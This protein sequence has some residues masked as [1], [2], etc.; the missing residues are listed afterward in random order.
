M[1]NLL[2]SIVLGLLFSLLFRK[3][4]KENCLV[5]ET[6]DP[7]EIRKRIVKIDENECVRFVPKDVKCPK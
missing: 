4:C 7:E 3:S 5:L 1:I 2:I 6:V